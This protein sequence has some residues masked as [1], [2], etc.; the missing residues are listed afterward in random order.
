MEY[1]ILGVYLLGVVLFFIALLRDKYV[2]L[3]KVVILVYV[4]A[5][6]FWFISGLIY[7]LDNKN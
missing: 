4:V 1:Y 5:S 3:N 7:L 6:I 2:E